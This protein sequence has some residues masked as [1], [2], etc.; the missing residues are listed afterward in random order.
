MS[1]ETVHSGRHGGCR[2]GCWALHSRH[3]DPERALGYYPQAQDGEAEA[4]RGR[5]VCPRKLPGIPSRPSDSKACSQLLTYFLREM[6][7]RRGREGKR[8]AQMRKSRTLRAGQLLSAHPRLLS[9]CPHA[10]YLRLC[11]PR[12]DARCSG[13]NADSS[14]EPDQAMVIPPDRATTLPP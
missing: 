11:S 9:S 13:Q 2:A 14:A 6:R 3:S 10:F 12:P 4:G 5:A 7:P 8:E 1:R